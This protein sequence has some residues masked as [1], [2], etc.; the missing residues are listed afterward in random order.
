VAGVRWPADVPWYRGFL[1][2]PLRG[3][4]VAP[5]GDRLTVGGH[6]FAVVPT[7]GHTADHVCLFE[8][9]RRWLFAGDLY[10]D[11]RLDAQLP[12]VDGPRWIASL[13]RAAALDAAVLFDGHGLVVR[14]E[15]AVRGALEAKRAFLE[16]VRAR[17]AREAP[18][19]RSL[20]ELTR[21]VFAVR[22]AAD[23]LSRHE[24]RMSLLTRTDFARSHLVRTFLP[25]ADAPTR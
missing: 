10:V 9:E 6:D 2:G 15:A 4:R 12:D 5:L 22:G 17:T 18:F 3:S 11:E 24:G 20:P 13:E 21:R 8:P 7:P 1:F 14:G 19:A 16:D 25:E 23:R